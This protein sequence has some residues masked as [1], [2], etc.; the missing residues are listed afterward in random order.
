MRVLALTNLYPNPYQPHRAA[1]NR[2]QLAA[3]AAEHEVQVIAPIAW[4]GEWLARRHPGAAPDLLVERRRVCDGMIVHHPRFAF[5]PRILHGQ[6]GRFFVRSVRGVFEA[7]VRSLRPDV[8]LG[9][10][11]YPDG[12][13]ALRLGREAGLPVAI[14]VQGSDLLTVGAY[15]PRERRTIEAITGA[16]GVIAVSRNLGERAVAMGAEAARVHV[17]YNGVDANMF[18]PGDRAAARRRVGITSGDPMILA[19]GNL[20]P[21]KGFDVLID[22]LGSLARAGVRFR[23]DVVGEGPS[24]RKLQHQIQALGLTERVRLLGAR[25]LEELPH[26]YRSAD[27]VVLASRSE[28]IPNVL[29]EAG[30]CGARCV[31][32]RVGGIPEIVHADSLVAPG[33]AAAL[34]ERIGVFLRVGDAPIGAAPLLPRSWTDSAQALAQALRVIIKAASVRVSRAG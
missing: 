4:T 33:D 17:V 9:C 15:P 3:L 6:H 10:W 20:A 16:D 19:V 8:V 32:T 22:A 18:F 28:G 12:W 2:Q 31:A 29:L 23:C 24:R 26:W 7:V 30:A 27:L 34:A 5:T 11:A 13:A 14:K 21:V 25:P 1:F